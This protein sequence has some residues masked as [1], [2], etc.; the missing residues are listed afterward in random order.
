MFYG[1]KVQKG[2][3]LYFYNGVHYV[4]IKTKKLSL[5]KHKKATNIAQNYLD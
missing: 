2:K 5:T 3:M 4:S 1:Y